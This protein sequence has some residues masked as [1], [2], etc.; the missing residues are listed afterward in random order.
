[1][2]LTCFIDSP[3]ITS[4]NVNQLVSS[5][6]KN[7]IKREKVWHNLF[8]D[9]SCFEFM[10]LK[11]THP[12]GISIQILLGPMGN[13]QISLFIAEFRS[14]IYSSPEFCLTWLLLALSAVS[15]HHWLLAGSCPVWTLQQI[16]TDYNNPHSI[17][18]ALAAMLIKL[19]CMV[20]VLASQWDLPVLRKST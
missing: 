11:Q 8:V 7:D 16:I 12:C 15:S 3:K 14:R 1:M 4:T 17:D 6:Y 18:N 9:A 10:Y 20:L 2:E 5:K 13:K 19:I